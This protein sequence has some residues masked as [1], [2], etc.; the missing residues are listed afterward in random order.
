LSD[1]EAGNR[2]EQIAKENKARVSLALRCCRW[3]QSVA[4]ARNARD[5]GLPARVR[6]G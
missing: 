1:A 6:R 2:G 5:D 4:N 3:E